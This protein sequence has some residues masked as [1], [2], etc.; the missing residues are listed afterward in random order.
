MWGCEHWYLF[1]CSLTAKRRLC[2][3]CSDTR[4]K[5]AAYVKYVD[6]QGDVLAATQWE[7]YC[8]GCQK[9]GSEMAGRKDRGLRYLSWLRRKKDVATTTTTT[10]TTDEV[11]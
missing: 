4:E 6:G 11:S 7:Y 3:G 10:M 5:A 9:A 2:C 1:D 8:P